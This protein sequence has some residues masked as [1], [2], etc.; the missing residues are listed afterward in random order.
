MKKLFIAIVAVAGVASMTA[1]QSNKENTKSET[2]T[3]QTTTTQTPLERTIDNSAMA[4]PPIRI[5]KTKADYSN[6]VPI[7]M[8]DDKTQIVSYP[9]PA[10]VYDSKRPTQLNDGYLL[11][12]FG[13]GKNVVYTDYTF[14]QYAALESVP[15]L[16]T[17]MQHIIDR[18]PLTELYVSDKEY[19]RTAN[20]RSAEAL[21]AVI[22]NGMKGFVKAEL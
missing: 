12:N 16:E 1:C 15:E 6:L 9:D 18:N 20:G 4:M 14:E 11:D 17:L 13:I 22:D 19:P 2:T 21:N 10:D 7:T 5:Y 3:T 8:N